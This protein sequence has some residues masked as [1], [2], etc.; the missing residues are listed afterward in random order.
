[1]LVVALSWV[2]FRARSVAAAVRMLASMRHFEWQPQYGTELA[3]LGIVSGVMLLID[4]RLELSGEEYPFQHSRLAMPIGVATA[5]AAV[6]I[7]YAASESNAFIY[8]QF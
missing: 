5:M 4:A 3:F 1:M 8:F 2:F 6:M 7:A